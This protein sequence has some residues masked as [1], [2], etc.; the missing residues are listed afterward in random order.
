MTIASFY[1]RNMPRQTA[2]SSAPPRLARRRPPAFPRMG[3]E[4]AARAIRSMEHADSSPVSIFAVTADAFDDVLSR[5]EDAGMDGRITKPL[6]VPE[7]L[8]TLRTKLGR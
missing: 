1:A 5:V 6:N 2:D 3:G 7:L 8:S 4:E